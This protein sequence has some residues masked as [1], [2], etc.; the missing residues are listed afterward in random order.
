MDPLTLVSTLLLQARVPGRAH[1][2]AVLKQQGG[3]GAALAGG[4]LKGG[5][6]R[7]PDCRW[8]KDGLRDWLALAGGLL[9][10][11]NNGLGRWGS[12]GEWLT[13]AGLAIAGVALP[14]IYLVSV[15]L[16]LIVWL[17]HI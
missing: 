8:V 9:T 6:T 2:A 15:G 1:A 10:K 16:V 12:K 7:Q 11:L 17:A 3:R 4:L 14:C 5:A 13:G